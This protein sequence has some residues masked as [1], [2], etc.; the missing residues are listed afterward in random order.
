MI[1]WLWQNVSDLT[2]AFILSGGNTLSKTFFL[3]AMLTDY[4][5]AIGIRVI[6]AEQLLEAGNCIEASSH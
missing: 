6:T 4:S 5:R 1:T 2:N 3:E